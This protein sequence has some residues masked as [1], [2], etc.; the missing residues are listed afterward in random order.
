MSMDLQAGGHDEPLAEINV[1]PMVD[2][3]LSLLIIFMVASPEPPNEQMPLN[4]PQDTVVQQPAD[5][6][7]TLLISIDEKGEARLGKMPLSRDYD[8]MVEQLSANE[9]V[10]ADDK[11]V[12]RA[13]GAVPYGQ[14]VRIMAAAHDAG[15][16]EVGIA[17]QRL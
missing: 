2:V 3:L 7:A 14:V 10:Q 1:T 4:I 17:S 12:V 9:K 11:V 6:N 5:P 15:I 13:N 16:D 8:E